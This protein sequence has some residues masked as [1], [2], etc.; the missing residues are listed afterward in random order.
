M[1]PKLLISAVIVIAAIGVALA[2]RI[3]PKANLTVQEAKQREVK[4]LVKQLETEP[5]GR[6]PVEISK[7]LLLRVLPMCSTMS[8]IF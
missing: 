2:W 1:R 4:V 7:L 5:N 6:V 3:E 8:L